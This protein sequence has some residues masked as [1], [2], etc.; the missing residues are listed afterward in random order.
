LSYLICSYKYHKIGDNFILNWWREKFTPIYNEFYNLLPKTSIK[1]LG[2]GSG[3]RKK[4]Y[5]GSRIQ[6]Q[7]STRSRI[8]I[9]NTGFTLKCCAGSELLCKFWYDTM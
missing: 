2:L 3:I 9:S 5:S 7:K 4:T 6:G 8:R 1:N